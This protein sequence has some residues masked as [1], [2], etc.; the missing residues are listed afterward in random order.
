MKV[1]LSVDQNLSDVDL[2]FSSVKRVVRVI[3]RVPGRISK[4]VAGSERDIR[5]PDLITAFTLLPFPPSAL[6]ISFLV[7]PSPCQYICPWFP[8]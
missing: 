1:P 3:G 4:P 6:Q 2:R 8:L 7:V 5:Q